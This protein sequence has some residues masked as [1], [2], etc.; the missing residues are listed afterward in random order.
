MQN[1]LKV[2]SKKTHKSHILNAKQ[3]IW[4]FTRESR[5]VRPKIVIQIC[6]TTLKKSYKW[7]HSEQVWWT[8]GLAAMFCGCLL[9]NRSLITEL[10]HKRWWTGPD[11]SGWHCLQMFF[12]CHHRLSLQMLLCATGDPENADNNAVRPQ[13]VCVGIKLGR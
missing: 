4:L 11:R 10:K 13:K 8:K 1:S 6:L 9:S 7:R 3:I 5:T 2:Y 12:F